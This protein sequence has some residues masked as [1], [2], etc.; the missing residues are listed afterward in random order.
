MAAGMSIE[1]E[2]ELRIFVFSGDVTPADL[3]FIGKFYADREHYR[4]TDRAIIYFAPDTS[5]AQID[6]EDLGDLADQYF[7]AQ[8][9]RDDVIV[10]KSV[11]VLPLQVRSEAR[12]WREFTRDPEIMHQRSQVDTL[13]AALA[14]YDLPASWMEDIRQGT[15]FR[16][17]G[18]V[19]ALATAV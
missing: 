9:T 10:E 17:F 1:M 16:Q 18:D 11:W 7:E 2:R 19:S 6:T 14:A 13:A 5:L 8:R 12:I 15:G 3:D 4:F